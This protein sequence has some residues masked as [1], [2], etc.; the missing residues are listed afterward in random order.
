MIF[1]VVS[2]ENL[3]IVAAAKSLGIE[4]IELQH[5]TI[6]DYHLGYSYPLKTRLDGEIPY[7]PDKI[8]TFGDYWI[9]DENCPLS[10]DKIIPIGF[11]YFEVQSKDYIN[12]EPIDNQVLFI[13]Q[14]V[15][16][17]YLSQI[18]YEFAKP[19]KIIKSFI[20]CIPES[21]RPGGRTIRNWLK[22]QLLITLKSL[23]IVKFHYMS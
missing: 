8:L 22:H 21:M 20:N 19:K 18:A 12:A 16:G 13:S 7:F 11:S 1:V 14:G 2:Y 23:M 4:V 10:K 17:K 3:A 6:T 15:I 9:N 5:G